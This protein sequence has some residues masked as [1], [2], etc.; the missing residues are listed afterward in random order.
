MARPGRAFLLPILTMCLETE[1]LWLRPFQ[2]DD[3]AD[4]FALYSDP[5]VMSCTTAGVRNRAQTKERLEPII[6]H[7]QQHGFGIW[8]LILQEKGCF[9]GTCGFGYLHDQRD[10][11]LAYR[12]CG[13]RTVLMVRKAMI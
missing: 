6:A 7:R 4:L 12:L 2:D 10:V 13:I 5:E 9:I 8:A 1:R 11:E 3:C